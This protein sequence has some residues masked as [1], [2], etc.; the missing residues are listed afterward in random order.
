M[1]A[2]PEYD[3][4]RRATMILGRQ[5]VVEDAPLEPERALLAEWE[6][7]GQMSRVQEKPAF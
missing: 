4:G 6:E 1:P 5:F 3:R 2:W 7:T